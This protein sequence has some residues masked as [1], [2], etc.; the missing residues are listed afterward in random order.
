MQTFC[1]KLLHQPEEIAL[2]TLS[3][4]SDPQL[5]PFI[6]ALTL[7]IPLCASNVYSCS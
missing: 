7:S 5:L 2:C 6:Q 3:T 1:A 4:H